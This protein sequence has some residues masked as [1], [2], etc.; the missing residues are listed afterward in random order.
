MYS[1][2]QTHTQRQTNTKVNTKDTLSG[3][4]EFSFNLSSRIGPICNENVSNKNVPFISNTGEPVTWLWLPFIIF[5]LLLRSL[6]SVV[7]K[8]NSINK[9]RGSGSNNKRH[10]SIKENTDTDSCRKRS[11]CLKKK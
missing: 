7:A 8:S 11:F 5:Y 2:P 3:F 10:S 6:L 9:Y 4:E 1:S